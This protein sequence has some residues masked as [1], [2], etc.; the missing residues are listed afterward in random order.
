MSTITRSTSPRSEDP[1]HLHERLIVICDSG[2][3]RFA[4]DADCY[5]GVIELTPEQAANHLEEFHTDNATI[6]V[7]SLAE[8]L[9]HHFKTEFLSADGEK[10]LMT[11][12]IG[13]QHAAIRVA[14]VSQPTTLCGS[15]LHAVPNVARG[16]DVSGL[17]KG[18]AVIDASSDSAE[19]ILPLIDLA[20]AL[21]YQPKNE[22]GA[23]LHLHQMPEH[24]PVTGRRPQPRQ[25]LA[26]VPE[27]I[28][29]EDCDNYVFCLPVSTIAEV[30][31]PLELIKLPFGSEQCIGYVLWRQHPVPV[32][33]LGACLGLQQQ[34]LPTE[35]SKHKRRLIIARVSGNRFVGFY[36]RHQLQIIKTPPDVER[37][38]HDEIADRPLLGVFESEDGRLVF[39]DLDGILEG[40]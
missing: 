18:I 11:I 15:E 20:L 21:G 36:A 29:H 6:P 40:G 1:A 28:S 13:D 32:I 14:R 38:P 26:F 27:E 2:G 25:L 24:K 19:A 17:I 37:S 35:D 12:C 34:E 8:L 10:S 7:I 23:A 39:P 9:S 30:T 4:I 31:S 16:N 5:T 22:D 33:N 3:H